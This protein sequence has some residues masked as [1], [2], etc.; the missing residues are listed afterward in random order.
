MSIDRA[1]AAIAE[2]R[3]K[4]AKAFRLP[5]REAVRRHGADL[6]PLEMAARLRNRR[7]AFKK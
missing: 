2:F 3:E 1:D 6:D 5:F 4:N 7:Q